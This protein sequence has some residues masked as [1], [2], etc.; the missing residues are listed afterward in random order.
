MT[1]PE[2]S[3]ALAE[4]LA[5]LPE[6]E[7]VQG[8]TQWVDRLAEWRRL[9]MGIGLGV[10]ALLGLAAILTVTVGT[11]LVLHARRQE[12]EVMRLVGAPESAVWL[13]LVLQGLMQ[14]LVAAL[15]AVGLLALGY[16]LMLP[17]LGP[18]F[19]VTLG[20]T[21]VQFFSWVQIVSL[22]GGG[23][24]LGALGGLLARGSRA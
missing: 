24:L 16:R 7:E 15:V 14:G 20:L 2:G 23:G 21:E 22:V 8:G 3:R 18:L 12:I 6:V 10:G 13:P 11:T 9:L 17:R 19:T 4:Q 1:T 5:A